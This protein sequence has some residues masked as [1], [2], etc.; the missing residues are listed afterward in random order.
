MSNIFI[1]GQC[2]TLLQRIQ[3]VTSTPAI[4]LANTTYYTSAQ[5]ALTFSG[6][7][8]D[9]YRYMMMAGKIVSAGNDSTTINFN[10]VASSVYDYRV[11]QPNSSSANNVYTGAAQTFIQIGISTGNN[12][13]DTFSWSMLSASGQNRQI[14][15][16]YLRG[17]SSGNDISAGYDNFGVWRNSANEIT[18][19]SLGYASQLNGFKIGTEVM[20]FGIV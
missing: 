8:G 13:I 15:G 10:G 20:L 12:T 19:V 2:I 1:T 5:T 18:S 16:Q 9:S 4:P 3:V 14:V 6:L 7:T 11:T 17:A